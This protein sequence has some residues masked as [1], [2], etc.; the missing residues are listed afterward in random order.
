[1]MGIMAAFCYNNKQDPD[2]NIT[3]L[4]KSL[5]PRDFLKIIIGLRADDALFAI[6]VNRWKDNLQKLGEL[7]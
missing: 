4:M 3:Y 1:M 7:K 6:M 2:F 5:Q